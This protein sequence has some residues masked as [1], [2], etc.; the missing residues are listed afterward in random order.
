MRG[1]RK[2]KAATLGRLPPGMHG[3]GG[4]LWL[5][6]TTSGAR[7]WIFRFRL[8]GRAREM[9]LG[10]LQVVTLGQ[11]RDAALGCRQQVIAGTDPIEARR[12]G[13]AVQKPPAPSFCEC[14]EAFIAAHRADWTSKR[15]AGQWEASVST[16]V[17]PEIGDL[18]VD[19]I[20]TEHVLKVLS[21][22]WTV[23]RETMRRVRG[24]I[25]AILDYAAAKKLREGDNPARW[26][27]HLAHLLANGAKRQPPRHFAA[28]PYAELPAFMRFL[29]TQ[30]RIAARSLEF[31]ILT[32]ARRDEVRLSRW[33]EID[34]TGRLW[35]VPPERMKAGREHRVPLSEAALSIL[36]G[37]PR[38][39]DF[40]F[41]G[42]SG[43]RM[44]DE[45]RRLVRA[46]LGRRATVHG[47]RSTFADWAAERT[48]FPSEAIE[49]ALAHAIS[50]RV[51]AAYRRGDL[52]EKRRQLAEAW[53]QYCG[54]EEPGGRDIVLLPRAASA[55]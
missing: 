12:S 25:E 45:M 19:A 10:S 5:Q 30:P 43:A 33:S 27:G 9:G 17:L 50:S 37:V 6:V 40:V 21:P 24:R 7:S 31:L 47:F 8:A 15:H 3:D 1:E 46:A 26:R 55:R 18:P 35:V 42:R 51:V 13:Q 28:L 48:D 11:A 53:A 22:F 38:R 41:P 29:S 52:F 20:N 44:E 2:L 36:H 4:G 16:Y 54:G 14:A 49:I 39:N 34:L 23:K 32:A